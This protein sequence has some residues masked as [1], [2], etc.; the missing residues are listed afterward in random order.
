MT[1]LQL[2]YVMQKIDLRCHYDEWQLK[3]AEQEHLFSISTLTFRCLLP[4]R[5]LRS[6]TLP[7]KSNIHPCMASKSGRWYTA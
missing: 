1:M 2:I 5:F 3:T 7:R 6:Y 4:L